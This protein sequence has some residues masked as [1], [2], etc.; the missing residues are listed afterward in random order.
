MTTL[1]KITTLNGFTDGSLFGTHIPNAPL[2]VGEIPVAQ[3]QPQPIT[4]TPAGDEK[5][6]REENL[7]EE[8]AG[9]DRDITVLGAYYSV[10]EFSYDDVSIISPADK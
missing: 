2:P 9:K 8:Q 4:E 6:D 10:L 7:E 5:I 1:N 3:Q